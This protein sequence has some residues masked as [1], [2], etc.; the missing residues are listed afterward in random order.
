LTGFNINDPMVLG[1]VVGFEL[2]REFLIQ[3]LTIR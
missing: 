1:S 2:P 3:R